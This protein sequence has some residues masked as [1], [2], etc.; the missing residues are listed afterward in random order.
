MVAAFTRARSGPT[1][2]TH[3][4]VFGNKTGNGPGWRFVCHVYVTVFRNKT[5]NGLLFDSE[6]PP[7]AGALKKKK[8]TH[9]DFYAKSAQICLRQPSR[10]NAILF[11]FR[12]NSRNEK[13]QM[14]RVCHG[15]C[16]VRLFLMKRRDSP[17]GRAQTGAA[18]TIQL[19]LR[20]PRNITV[21][22]GTSRLHELVPL[23]RRQTARAIQ[24]CVP[25]S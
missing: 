10:L 8:K 19:L 4:T 16:V 25:G 3:V 15:G 21:P 20:A 12:T 9:Q 7:A 18:T 24:R 6:C 2:D 17:P 1:I 23:T 5:R 22:D 14:C 11:A 13:F